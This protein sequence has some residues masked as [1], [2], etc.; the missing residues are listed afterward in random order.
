MHETAKAAYKWCTRDSPVLETDE[1]VFAIGANIN[2]EA[3]ENEDNDGN[4]F[5]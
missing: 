2:K 3:E 5:K 4:N 1:A